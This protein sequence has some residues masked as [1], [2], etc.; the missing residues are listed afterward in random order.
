LVDVSCERIRDELFKI[1]GQPGSFGCLLMLDSLGVLSLIM[2][3][4]EVMRGIAQGP[5]HHLDVLKHSFETVN[6]LEI[7]MSEHKN[8]KEINPYLDEVIS[9]ERKRRALLKLGALLHDIGKPKAKRRRNKKTIFHGHERIGAGITIEI[10]RR[11]KLSNNEID[12]LRK[13]VFWHLRPGYLAD[14]QNITPRAMFRYFRDAA[15]E[16]VS[17][18]LL[19]IADQRATKGRLTSEESRM[20]H[21]KTVSG[22]IKEYFRRK[23]EKKLL[24]LLNG[25]DLIRQFKLHPSPLIGKILGYVE[26][27]QAINKIKTKDEAL[28]AAKRIINKKE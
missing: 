1:F 4:I 18:L 26:E 23:K 24:R 17:I 19:S 9:S 10:A 8:N 6:Q 13:M 7:L 27:L 20:Q 3:E 28:C 22:L 21:E 14:N 25:D 2:P 5:Y 16:G 15:E 12:S 11:L